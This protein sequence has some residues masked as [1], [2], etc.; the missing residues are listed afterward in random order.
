MAIMMIMTITNTNDGNDDDILQA[1]PPK[2]NDAGNAIKDE[3]RQQ[4]K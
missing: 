2:A 3:Q 4:K 1:K